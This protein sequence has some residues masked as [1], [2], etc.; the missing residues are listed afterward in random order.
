MSGRPA[1]PGKRVRSLGT[2]DWACRLPPSALTYQARV[3]K[4][5]EYRRALI[6]EIECSHS[7]R[8]SPDSR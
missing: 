8:A 7:L 6:G 3:L 5:M 1:K 2:G 4:V